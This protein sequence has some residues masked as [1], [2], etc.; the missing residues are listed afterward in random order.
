MTR[1]SNRAVMQHA[2][3]LACAL[4]VLNVSLA[5]G[6]IWPTPAIQWRGDLSVELALVVLGLAL[7]AERG[8][9]P[10]RRAIGVVLM[11]GRY[12]DV[13]VQSLFGRE[14]NLYW[15]ARNFSAVGG[16]LAFVAR[17]GLVLL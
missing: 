14:L 7:A 6:N 1:V 3:L 2:L 9:I 4:I 12:A 10:S 13:T 5:F 15:D 8:W 17:P 11:I 16:M